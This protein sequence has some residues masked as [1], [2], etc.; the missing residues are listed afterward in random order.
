M[1]LSLL[2]EPSR[3]EGWRE[4]PPRG[5]GTALSPLCADSSNASLRYMFA[6]NLAAALRTAPYN[7][8]MI[9]KFLATLEFLLAGRELRRW[10]RSKHTITQSM[11]EEEARRLIVEHGEGAIEVAEGFVER[12][13]TDKGD[14]HAHGR[15]KRVLK[16]IQ[17]KLASVS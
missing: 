5:G 7:Q 15:W 8:G 17:S 6:K 10:F 16:A 4:A 2:S 14:K 1:K 9:E 3:S 11:I 12:A 13:R